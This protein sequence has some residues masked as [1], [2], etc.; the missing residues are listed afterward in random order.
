LVLLE[1]QVEMEVQATALEI[2]A[3]MEALVT[4]DW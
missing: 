4:M 2:L 3:Q 1:V